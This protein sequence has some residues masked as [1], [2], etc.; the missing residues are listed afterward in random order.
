MADDIDD[1]LDEVEHKFVKAKTKTV[2][3]R[4]SSRKKSDDEMDDIINDIC[5]DPHAPE[6][7]NATKSAQSKTSQTRP[8]LSKCFPVFIGGAADP[9]GYGNTVNKRSCNKLRCTSCDFLVASFDNFTWDR[10]TDYLFLRNNSPDFNRLKSKLVSKRG[11]RAY[12]CQCCHQAVDRLTD[13]QT[14]SVKWACTSH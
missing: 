14:L 10:T 3:S 8:K 5:G 9:Q 12:C 4:K 6:E 13:T 1:L 7:S 11:W 2:I